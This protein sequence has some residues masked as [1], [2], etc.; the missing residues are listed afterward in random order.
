MPRL[1]FFNDVVAGRDVTY[2]RTI[3]LAGF[4]L[5]FLDQIE[6]SLQLMRVAQPGELMRTMVHVVGEGTYGIWVKAGDALAMDA[7]FAHRQLRQG[8]QIE[9]VDLVLNFVRNVSIA[10]LLNY[11]GDECSRRR[12][13]GF[14]L[15]TLLA[16]GGDGPALC[17]QPLNPSLQ[18]VQRREHHECVRI[19]LRCRNVVLPEALKREIDTLKACGLELL[20]QLADQLLTL[21]LR[22]AIACQILDAL[23]QRLL[24]GVRP[25]AIGITELPVDALCFR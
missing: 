25:L 14:D 5:L 16:V 11:I 15:I 19:V 8:L 24:H 17:L 21:R 22:N 3:L 10:Q 12:I 20:A 23:G 13:F 4:L 1:E 7:V 2:V 18:L 6:H 9:L